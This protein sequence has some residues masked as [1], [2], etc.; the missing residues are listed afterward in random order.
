MKEGD[1]SLPLAIVQLDGKTFAIVEEDSYEGESYVIL[2]IRKNKVRR[3][4]ETL[5]GSC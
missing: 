4:L 1:L 3:I 2:E 5:A